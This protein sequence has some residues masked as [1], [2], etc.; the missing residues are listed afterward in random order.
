L[1]EGRSKEYQEQHIMHCVH[2]LAE[3]AMCAGDAGI[4]TFNWVENQR[5][6][7][8]DFSIRKQCRDWRKLVEWQERNKVEDMQKKRSEM[9]RPEGGISVGD[10]A[11]AK[12]V[13]R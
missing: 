4:I 6:P 9:R 5:F 12:G 3:N 8:P 10:A 13:A 2:M 7:V 11:E 1:G